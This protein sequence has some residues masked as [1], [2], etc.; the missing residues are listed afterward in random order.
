MNAPARGPG[1]GTLYREM[2]TRKGT[3]SYCEGPGQITTTNSSTSSTVDYWFL[4]HRLV[5]SLFLLRRTSYSH[6]YL[7]YKCG[8]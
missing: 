1:Q 6:S 7:V 4:T 3:R 2:A 5:V 8:A